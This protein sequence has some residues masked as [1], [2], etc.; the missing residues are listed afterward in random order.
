MTNAKHISHAASDGILSHCL[1]NIGSDRI[2]TY[3]YFINLKTGL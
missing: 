2:F 1:P 3:P